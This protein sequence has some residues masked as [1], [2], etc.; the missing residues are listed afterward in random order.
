[1]RYS[2]PELLRPI[3]LLVCLGIG[4]TGTAVAEETETTVSWSQR[5]AQLALVPVKSVLQGVQLQWAEDALQ[6]PAVGAYFSEQGLALHDDR[7]SQDT[8]FRV[9]WKPAA[10]I[11][12]QVG[13]ASEDLWA[14]P[15]P[16]VYFR[17]QHR[18]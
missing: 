8:V 15:R 3:S 5:G 16:G 6:H 11:Q 9:G 13:L 10:E 2:I 18:W 4:L 7:R 1:M 12:T 17:L 14:D